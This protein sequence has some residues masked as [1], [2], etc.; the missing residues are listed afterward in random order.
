MVW[1]NNM[2]NISRLDS[3]RY[4]R[5]AWSFFTKSN[6]SAGFQNLQSA[7]V[8]IIFL[9]SIQK[10]LSNEVYRVD[11][12]VQSA[13]G[14]DS[15]CFFLGMGKSVIRVPRAKRLFCIWGIRF[16]FTVIHSWS[17]EKK[18]PLY[19]LLQNWGSDCWMLLIPNPTTF[20]ATLFSLYTERDFF[21]FIFFLFLLGRLICMHG[22][23]IRNMQVFE[24]SNKIEEKDVIKLN[25]LT[26]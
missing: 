7:V 21:L 12:K 23:Q 5:V 24:N 26:R 19:C 25:H 2:A 16:L 13:P 1:G 8:S 22:L 10:K 20:C 3:W 18:T 17:G 14:H 4:L 11:F 9:F 15:F 6:T